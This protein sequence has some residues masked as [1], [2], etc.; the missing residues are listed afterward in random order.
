MKKIENYLRAIGH[1]KEAVDIYSVQPENDLYRDG[2][3][4]RFE[5]TVELAWKSLKEYL[6]D[7]GVAITRATPKAILK[8][9]FAAGVIQEDQV[10]ILILHARNLTSHIYTEETAQTIARQVCIDFLPTLQKLETFYLE[11]T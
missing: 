9:A 10:W 11:N 6:E 2:L 5:F 4:Q 7:Q 3:I 8:D 1:L